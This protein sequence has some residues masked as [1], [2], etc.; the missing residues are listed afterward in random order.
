MEQKKSFNP[1][2]EDFDNIVKAKNEQEEAKGQLYKSMKS[3]QELKVE[4]DGR[5]QFLNSLMVSLEEQNSRTKKLK[6]QMELL[7]LEKESLLNSER[8]TLLA[9]KETNEKIIQIQ[10]E[11]ET[12]YETHERN[13]LSFCDTL[14]FESK[15]ITARDYRNRKSKFNNLTGSV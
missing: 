8:E 3:V 12:M 15:I 1:Y 13:V 7:N 2:L 14:T 9:I 6:S 10:T 4:L 5:N 11:S